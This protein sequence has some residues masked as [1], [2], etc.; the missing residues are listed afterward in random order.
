MWVGKTL[1]GQMQCLV[2]DKATLVK[3]EAALS[4]VPA[5]SFH[6]KPVYDHDADFEVL[7]TS[8]RLIDHD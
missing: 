7:T 2:P 8:T 4:I 3:L 6:N 1:R 5:A